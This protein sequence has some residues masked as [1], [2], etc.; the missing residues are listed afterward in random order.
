MA[1]EPETVN[2]YRLEVPDGYGRRH[3]IWAPKSNQKDF[4]ASPVQDKWLDFAGSGVHILSLL[5]PPAW[6]CHLLPRTHKLIKRI[7]A[8]E[9][10]RTVFKFHIS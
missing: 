5:A 9:P 6:G 4:T 3:H 10:E 7:F 1:R 2:W 8:V